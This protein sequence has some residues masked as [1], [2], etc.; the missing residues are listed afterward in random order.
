MPSA[1]R[2]LFLPTQPSPQSI[3]VRSC[4]R[5][6]SVTATKDSATFGMRRLC[7]RVTV[8]PTPPKR[9]SS[10]TVSVPENPAPEAR[11][12]LARPVRAGKTPARKRLPLARPFRASLRNVQARR[13]IKGRKPQRF[14]ARL[15][16]SHPPQINSY[17]CVA[18]RATPIFVPITSPEIMIST[19]RFCCRPA[20]VSLLATGFDFPNP[21]A[22][23]EFGSSPCVIK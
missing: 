6:G 9:P 3:A 1:A 5:G 4:S 16:A 8:P 13:K 14:R 11:H 17:C 23:I 7:R 12:K 2:E 10:L 18:P 20:G 22:V 19:L 21:V 15:P